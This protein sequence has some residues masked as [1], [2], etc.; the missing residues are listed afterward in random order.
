MKPRV[1]TETLK[2]QF[3]GKQELLKKIY[4]E[5]SLHV[6]TVLPEM[7]TAYEAEDL[8]TLAEKAHTLKGNA[9][10]IGATRVKELALEIQELSSNGNVHSLSWA[11]S[12]LYD[13][14][15]MAL[16]ELNSFISDQS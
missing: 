9:A 14:V 10:L 13:E 2:V 7:R 4:H 12:Q 6:D 8:K 16:Q 3:N 1:D 5:F 11:L 15:Q